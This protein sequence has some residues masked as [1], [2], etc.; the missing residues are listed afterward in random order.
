LFFAQFGWNRGVFFASSLFIE[1]WSFY[2][3]A[4]FGNAPS[5][6]FLRL[7]LL[8]FYRIQNFCSIP[9]ESKLSCLAFDFTF[10]YFIRR[11]LIWQKSM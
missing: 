11:K 9:F 5:L 10:G 8:A 4:G 6:G 2:F 1:G 3:Y 7:H